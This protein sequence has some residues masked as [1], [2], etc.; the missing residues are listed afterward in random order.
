L[1]DEGPMHFAGTI[2][3][4]AI[5]IGPSRSLKM[6]T[7]YRVLITALTPTYVPFAFP[8]SKE[9]KGRRQGGG[10]AAYAVGSL[11]NLGRTLHSQKRKSQSQSLEDFEIVCAFI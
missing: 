11:F 2:D 7:E 10:P 9:Y 6:T 1:P 8:L 5:C 3:A 4:A